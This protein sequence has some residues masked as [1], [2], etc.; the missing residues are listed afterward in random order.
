M[1]PTDRILEAAEEHQV[2]IIGLS[3]LITPSLDEMVGVAREMERR[4]M[5]IPLLIGG[6]TTSKAHTAVKIAPVYG[7][8]V[9]HVLDASRSVPVVSTLLNPEQRQAFAARNRQEQDNMRDGYLNRAAAKNMLSLEQARARC[10]KG[11]WKNYQPTV[12]VQAGVQQELAWPLEELVDYIDWTP[13]FQ[14]WELHGRFPDLLKDEVVGEAATRLFED[15]Q[16]MLQ[17]LVNGNLLTAKAVWGLFP[18]YATSGDVLVMDKQWE[19]PMLRQQAAK[20]GDLPNFCLSDFVAPQESG[21]QDWAGAFAVGIF[22]AEELAQKHQQNHDDFSAIMVKALADRLA[23]A[24]AEALHAKV[25]Q[26]D[27]GYAPM[28]QYSN[29]D[30]IAEKYRGIRPAPGY[31]ACPD[32][33]DKPTIWK[34]LGVEERLGMQ[35]TESLAMTPAAAVSGFYLAHPESRYFG[36]GKIAADQLQDYALRRRMDI[37]EA[38]RWLAPVL[39]DA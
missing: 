24:L 1:V 34:M 10:W 25:R 2:D 26:E 18:A 12:P 28:E 22:G 11:D 15:A 33:L 21:V 13:F 17:T 9:V 32:H 14:A 3:G 20:A 5:Q 19:F 27:W 8:T 6:A 29:A 36:V 7:G 31:P 4:G 30:L 37:R 38:R 23:E 35:L 39:L 16:Q